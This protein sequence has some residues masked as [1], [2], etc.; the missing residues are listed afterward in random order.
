MFIA[1]FY[2]TFVF[3]TLTAVASI[4]VASAVASDDAEAIKEVID[5]KSYS[6]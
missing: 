2:A 4:P 6:D 3:E 1:V 5:A